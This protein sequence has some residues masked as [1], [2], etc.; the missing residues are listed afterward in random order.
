MHAQTH[1]SIP[2]FQGVAPAW[3]RTGDIPLSQRVLDQLQVAIAVLDTQGTVLFCNL[4]AQQF[5]KESDAVKL[6]AG[7]SLRFLDSG[8]ER[9]FQTALRRFA[10]HDSLG[11]ESSVTIVA[12]GRDKCDHPLISTLHLLSDNPRAVLATLA[13]SAGA[14]SEISLQCFSEAF[15]LTTAERRLARYLASGGCLIDAAKSFGVSRHTVRN[16]LRSIF[17]K[18]GVQRQT[19]LTRL[20]LAGSACDGISQVNRMA[21]ASDCAR[22]PIPLTHL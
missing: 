9:N 7:Q 13:D 21:G 18:V 1:Q 6:N 11:V 15:C 20:I 16:Q 10:D 19:D 3:D 17:D 22:R 12:N 4:R 14:P 8:A 2:R 5:A